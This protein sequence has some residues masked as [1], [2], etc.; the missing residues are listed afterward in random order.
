MASRQLPVKSSLPAN[1]TM[2]RPA[3]KM[4][5]LTSFASDGGCT[6]AA[7]T[8]APAPPNPMEKAGQNGQN[9][10]SGHWLRHFSLSDLYILF[11]DFCR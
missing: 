9:E 6:V 11:C 3:G 8:V 7:A 5:A 2:V 1:S 10:H 4:Q